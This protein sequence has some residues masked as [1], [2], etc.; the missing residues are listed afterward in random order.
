MDE[1]KA[2]WFRIPPMPE[3]DEDD[4]DGPPDDEWIHAA[5]ER[6]AERS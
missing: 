2:G 3:G 5:Y 4:D 6:Q 1:V